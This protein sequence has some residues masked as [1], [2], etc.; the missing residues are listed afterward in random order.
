MLAGEP[1]SAILIAQGL[2]MS[3]LLS[4]FLIFYPDS[5]AYHCAVF[6]KKREGR[7]AFLLLYWNSWVTVKLSLFRS[8]I[9]T[10]GIQVLELVFWHRPS[11]PSH[12]AHWRVPDDRRGALPQ[13]TPGEAWA[14]P[15]DCGEVPLAYDYPV[16]L[17]R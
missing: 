10:W 3:Y 5:I 7:R 16:A 14:W 13:R 8:D 6:I 2:L 9:I 12:L 1:V 11:G 4:L 15:A 17:H